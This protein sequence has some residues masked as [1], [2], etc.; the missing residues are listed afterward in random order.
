METDRTEYFGNPYGTFR[1]RVMPICANMGSRY[2]SWLMYKNQVVPRALDAIIAHCYARKYGGTNINPNI[3]S[4][5]NRF[6]DFQTRFALFRI[7]RMLGSSKTTVRRNEN[8]IAKSDFC[9]VLDHCFPPS[10]LVRGMERGQRVR[11][12]CERRHRG[13]HELGDV[14]RQCDCVFRQMAR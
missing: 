6:C 7:S 4:D 5:G 8:M 14:W 10:G 13:G 3:I 1:F 9:T 11:P 12:V 2:R